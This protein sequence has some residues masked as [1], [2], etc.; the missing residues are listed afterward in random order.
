MAGIEDSLFWIGHGSFYIKGVGKTIIID[1]FKITDR[2]REEADIL[3]ITHGH[4]DHCN[5]EDLARVVKAETRIISAEGCDAVKGYENVTIARPGFKQ[6]VEGV[7]IEAVPAYN[8][9]PKKQEYHPRSKNW[10]GYVIR[11]PDMTVYHAGDTDFIPEMAEL[12]GK[13][14]DVALLPIGGTYTM[15][16]EDAI[17]AA[18]A[19]G[20]KRTVPMHFK[21]LLGREGSERAIREFK[22][23]VKGA[24]ILEEVQEP[25]YGF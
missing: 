15:D 21:N 24:L 2:V 23:R 6:I 11:I 25:T 19:I 5:E 9:D 16:L 12:K 4:F 3:L 20:A 17:Q 1:P 13:G 10:V 22:S 7:E 14:I 8:T 18:E